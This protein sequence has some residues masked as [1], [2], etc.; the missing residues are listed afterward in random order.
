VA[1]DAKLAGDTGRIDEPP[2]FSV[3]GPALGKGRRRRDEVM[4]L[5]RKVQRRVASAPRETAEAG[6]R[7][8]LELPPAPS[9]VHV[10]AGYA[11]R[12]PD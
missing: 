7:L 10:D 8:A 1:R 3:S 9:R 2:G 4:Q 12:I 11:G 5:A 6:V